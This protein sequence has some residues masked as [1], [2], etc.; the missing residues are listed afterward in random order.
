MFCP[1]QIKNYIITGLVSNFF[2][3]PCNRVTSSLQKRNHHKKIYVCMYAYF[4]NCT[5]SP[6]KQFLTNNNKFGGF[7][8]EKK[9]I[10]WAYLMLFFFV[11]SQCAIFFIDLKS[12]ICWMHIIFIVNIKGHCSPYGP[13]MDLFYLP[14]EVT[15][16]SCYHLF[17]VDYALP[18]VA[19]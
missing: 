4:L 2:K 3:A 16:P 10:S 15:I 7:G 19:Y 12:Y 5:S 14:T 11:L 6:R 18:F 8:K 9:I 13:Q 1:S 17:I